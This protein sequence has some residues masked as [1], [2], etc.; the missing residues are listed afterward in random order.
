M[1][2]NLKEING[3]LQY[4]QSIESDHPLEE[5][6]SASSIDF[7]V[8]IGDIERSILVSLNESARARNICTS[9]S[10]ARGNTCYLL[11]DFISFDLPSGPIQ[12]PSF[13]EV[14][15]HDAAKSHR[16]VL[17]KSFSQSETEE[18]PSSKNFNEM[19]IMFALIECK[20]F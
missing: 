4:A 16:N 10:M 18:D 20:L 12:F 13:A 5:F 15:A 1:Q 9:W 14:F 6:K 7:L 2:A 8:I 3:K 11:N 17:I 19:D